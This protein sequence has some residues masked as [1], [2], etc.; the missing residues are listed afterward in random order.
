MEDQVRLCE[1]KI[2]ITSAALEA[3]EKAEQKKVWLS[4]GDFFIKVAEADARDTLTQGERLRHPF[5]PR[6]TDRAQHCRL[7]C[8]SAASYV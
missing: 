6:R 3:V 1:S 5:R 8:C 4:M 7:R 2:A